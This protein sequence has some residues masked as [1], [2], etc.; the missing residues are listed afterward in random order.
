MRVLE[1]VHG[2]VSKKALETVLATVSKRDLETLHVSMTV[3]EIVH[4]MTW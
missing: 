2:T 3:S 4:L 1:M